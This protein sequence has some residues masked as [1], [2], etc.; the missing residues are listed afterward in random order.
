MIQFL[1]TLIV[2][3]IVGGLLYWL[4]TMLPIPDPFRTVMIVAVILIFIL[5]LLGFLF[6]GIDLP[7]MRSFSWLDQG[8]AAAVN[9]LA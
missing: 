1:L 3:C 9:F 6:G 7:R 8:M 2:F 5:V 4:V